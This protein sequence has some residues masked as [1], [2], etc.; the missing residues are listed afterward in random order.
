MSIEGI[1]D[2]IKEHTGEELPFYSAIFRRTAN[3][4]PPVFLSKEYESFFWQCAT[5]IPNW[6]PRVVAACAVTEGRAYALLGI[7]SRVHGHQ[8]AEDGLLS[9]AKDEAAHARLFVKLAR[10]AFDGN[11]TGG[12]LDDV[13][14]SLRTH[15]EGG[16]REG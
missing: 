9:H 2:E 3:D 12:N 1:L 15:K 4:V 11:Y 13:E 14:S 10:L 16:Y 6:L 8:L 5:S 7:W